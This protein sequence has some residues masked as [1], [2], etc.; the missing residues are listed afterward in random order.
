MRPPYAA[1]EKRAYMAC[2]R[3]LAASSSR[4]GFTIFIT[5]TSASICLF[6]QQL[7]QIKWGELLSYSAYLYRS[8]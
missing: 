6:F 7:K 4:E 2:K 5:G 3:F 1:P 8:E